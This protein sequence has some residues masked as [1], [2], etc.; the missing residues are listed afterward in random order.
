MNRIAVFWLSVPLVAIGIMS[1]AS[2]ADHEI[3]SDSKV[4]ER[5][6]IA[7]SVAPMPEQDPDRGVPVRYDPC[8]ELGDDTV[9]KSGFD[10]STRAR[11]DQVHTGYAF[12]GCGFK[13]ME[14]LNGKVTPV[15]NL[16][17]SSVD[18]SLDKFQQREGV[19]AAQIKVNGRDAITYSHREAETCNVVMTGPDGVVDI[20]VDSTVALTNWVAC[21]HAQEIA[22]TVEPA[23]PKK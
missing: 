15:G 8:S 20:A 9:S 5:P 13:K 6:S 17:V 2:K 7:A 11:A 12:I 21:D 14:N 3:S 19:N 16:T 23:L 1:C 18:L 22:A 10:P 4:S